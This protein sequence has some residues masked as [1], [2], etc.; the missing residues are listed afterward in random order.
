MDK[1][2]KK[3]VFS[4]EILIITLFFLVFAAG[5]AYAVCDC[6]NT[7][8]WCNLCD[9]S[10]CDISEVS[11]GFYVTMRER[12]NIKEDNCVEISCL[13]DSYESAQASCSGGGGSP[14]LNAF[15]GKVRHPNWQAPNWEPGSDCLNRRG[16]LSV[17]SSKGRL[18]LGYGFFQFIDVDSGQVTVTLSPP[19]NC[20]AWYPGLG[21]GT[22]RVI[23]TGTG[24]IVAQGSGCSAV[25]NFPGGGYTRHL[26]FVLDYDSPSPPT[27]SGSCSAAS[28]EGVAD[29]TCSLD[30][31]DIPNTDHYALRV[32]DQTSGASFECC[33]TPCNG[34]I[35]DDGYNIGF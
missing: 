6:F 27:L 18:E 33:P 34:D 9:D 22:W 8:I 5:K 30:W 2:G 15:D 24:G 3:V 29:S 19:T 1:I 12:C 11:P 35:C 16:N 10:F 7:D 21:C 20:D 26:D 13:C 4:I 31:N 23:N 25:F 14:F 32:N 28:G 17:V